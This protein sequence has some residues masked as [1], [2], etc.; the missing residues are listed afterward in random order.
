MKRILAAIKNDVQALSFR[1]PDGSFVVQ[2]FLVNHSRTHHLQECRA[3][4]ITQ[5][6]LCFIVAF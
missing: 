3:V 2:A 6:D 1:L 5:Y 4:Y